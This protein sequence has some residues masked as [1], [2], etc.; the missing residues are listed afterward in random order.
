MY[1][2]VLAERY[3]I[4]MYICDIVIVVFEIADKNPSEYSRV[5]PKHVKND[6]LK[7]Q[8]VSI[9]LDGVFNLIYT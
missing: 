6:K 5:W 4:Y 3:K 9:T 7:Y 1:I 8:Y 2:L